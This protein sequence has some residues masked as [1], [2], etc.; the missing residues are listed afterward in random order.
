MTLPSRGL[1]HWLTLQGVTERVTGAAILDPTSWGRHLGSEVVGAAILDLKSWGPPSWIW[2][3]DIIY[4]IVAPILLAITRK[5]K[6]TLKKNHQVIFSL[7]S[8]RWPSLKLLAVIVFESFQWQN[9]QRAITRKSQITFFYFLYVI[10]LISSISWPG[11]KLLAV[12]VF[13]ISWLQ[14]L[15]SLWFTG[16]TLFYLLLRSFYH[17]GIR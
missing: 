5:N 9:S 4:P 7:S 11:L 2:R 17:V 12:I 16:H 3:R 15:G 14:N 13:E 8:I 6:T 10:C 1:G